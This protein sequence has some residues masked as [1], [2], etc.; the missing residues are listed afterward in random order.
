MRQ[1]HASTAG[2]G[3]LGQALS[4]VPAHSAITIGK[5]ARASAS[6]WLELAR[7]LEERA[8]RTWSGL[9][10]YFAPVACRA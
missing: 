8:S 7:Q 3:E 4:T 6:K 1:L 2:I 10:R 5:L 9:I